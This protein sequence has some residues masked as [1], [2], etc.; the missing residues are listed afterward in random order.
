[1]P[2]PAPLLAPVTIAARSTWTRY[3][4]SIRLTIVTYPMS[5]FSFVDLTDPSQHG[6]Y[7]RWH[8][9]DHRPEN[10]A[11]PGVAW[12]DRW[13]R[14]E[15]YRAAGRAVP[16][17]AGVDYLAMYLFRDPLPASLAAW[18][19]LGEDS[20][21]WGRGP[22]IP[23]VERRM[24]A[25]FVPVKGYAAP[26]ALV[27]PDVLPFR[28][29]RGLHVTLSRYAETHAPAT[30][31]RYAWEDRALLPALL[32]LDGVAGAWTFSFDRHQRHRT[33]PIRGTA[34]DAP[35]SLRLR[36]LYLDGEP[37]ETTAA[38]ARTETEVATPASRA[39]AETE[40]VLL[41]TPLRTIVPWQDW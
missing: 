23:G 30:H 8:Q 38:I 40:E 10:L 18:D 35:G 9:L 29:N 12:G 39:A 37:L 11:L 20:F 41:S 31:D 24:T 1:M 6:A 4:T 17:Y 2:A 15:E 5:F 21:Q 14:P 34:E 19:R 25:F 27:S 7:N 22:L 26:S 32:D 28:P 3:Q 16:E 33:L 13:A 36:V